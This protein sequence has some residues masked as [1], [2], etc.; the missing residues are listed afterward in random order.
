M[1]PS[2]CLS[3]IIPLVILFANLFRG[4]TPTKS[5]FWACAA[6]VVIFLFSNFKAKDIYPGC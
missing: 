2:K 5:A 1:A 4:Y 6:A 3:L